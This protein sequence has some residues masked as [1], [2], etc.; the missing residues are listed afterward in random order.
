MNKRGGGV[1]FYLQKD[2]QCK[3]IDSTIIRGI[4]ERF[5]ALKRELINYNWD[6]VFVDDPNQAYDEFLSICL[7]LYN[8]HFPIRKCL[9][10]DK[11]VKVK[12]N[13]SCI[14]IY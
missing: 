3:I 9:A 1:A 10:K 6:K 11:P 4:M 14:R 12:I 2:F 7:E 5:E 13:T 8:K